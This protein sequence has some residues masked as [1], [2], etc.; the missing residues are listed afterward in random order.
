MKKVVEYKK[1]LIAEL[2]NITDARILDYGCGKGDF[3]ELLLSH[4]PKEIFVVD[5]NQDAIKKIHK[6]FGKYI[7]NGMISSKICLNPSDLEGN[8]YDKIICHN[9]LECVGDKL[10]F[11]N[12]FVSLLKANG[13]LVLSHHDFDSAI[14]NSQ[15]KELTRELIHYFA[16][17]KQSWQ[18]NC[19]GQMG[20]KLP[21]LIEL[22]LFNQSKC[23]TWR[24][25]EYN[26][27]SGTY[28]F[29]MADM[30]CDIGQSIFDKNIL[31]SWR[32]DLPSKIGSDL[33]VCLLAKHNITKRKI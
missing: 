9:V 8:H 26:F 6:N 29:L 15:Y 3:V 28:G 17:T 19:D 10:N 24:T 30:L 22:S 14:Y 25:V 33:A 23:K 12:S 16:D 18:E 13:L 2:G 20:R 27:C 7:S 5:S 11:I 32:K 1:R 21:G 4:K 31:Q